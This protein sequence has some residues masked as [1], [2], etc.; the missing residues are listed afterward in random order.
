MTTYMPKAR[1]E[2]GTAQKCTQFAN[3]ARHKLLNLVDRDTHDESGITKLFDNAENGPIC[4]PSYHLLEGGTV[5]YGIMDRI[6][7]GW[8]TEEHAH[9]LKL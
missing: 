9:D 5:L 6:V 7:S 4:I 2:D 1:G 8:H 3:C